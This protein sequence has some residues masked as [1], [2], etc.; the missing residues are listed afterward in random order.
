VLIHHAPAVNAKVVL[1]RDPGRRAEIRD[2]M[3]RRVLKVL[4][5][6]ARHGREAVVLGAWGCGAFGND[7]AM[8]ADLFAGA[9]AD[10]FRGAFARVT[11]AIVDWS[12]EERFIGPF[13][14][15]LWP[16]MTQ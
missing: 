16:L 14:T 9:L 8:V 4:A 6:A 5:V 13:R 11:F 15:A 1:E 3:H 12:K 10:N 2:A 7:P